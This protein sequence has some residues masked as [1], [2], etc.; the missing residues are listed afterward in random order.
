MEALA[1]MHKG[2]EQ[3]PNWKLLTESDVREARE[4]NVSLRLLRGKF[5][6]ERLRATR[7]AQS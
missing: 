1:K 3:A 7:E 2:T 4:S 5:V 6:R